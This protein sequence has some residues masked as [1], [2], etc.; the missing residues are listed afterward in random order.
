MSK[1]LDMMKLLLSFIKYA[2]Q[3]PEDLSNDM[4]AMAK[5]AAQLLENKR[6]A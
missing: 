1:S 5:L 2:K 4:H 3:N 6:P